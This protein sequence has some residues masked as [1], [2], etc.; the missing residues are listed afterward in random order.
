MAEDYS[1]QP[2]DCMSSIAFERGFFWKKLWNLGANA[3]LKT[4]RKNPNVLMTG[5]VVHIPDLTVKQVPCATD[6]QHQFVRKGVP[7]KLRMKLLDNKRKPRANLVYN[8]VIDGKSRSG[9]T[10]AKGELT[11][12]IPPNAKVGKLMIGKSEVINLNLGHL[13]P[14]SDMSGIKMRLANLGFYKGAIDSNLDDAAKSALSSFQN[15]QG[16]PVTG[17]ADDATKNQLQKLHGH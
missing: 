3:S 13:N 1:V 10:S 14:V 11:E 6:K 8:I 17:A 9:K 12:S 16:L 4:S 7:E 5:D 2:G 15:A